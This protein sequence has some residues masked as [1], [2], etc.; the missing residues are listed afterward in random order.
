[1]L[2]TRGGTA[3]QPN[4][5]DVINQDVCIGCARCFKVCPRAVLQ[6]AGMTEDGEQVDFDD[7]EAFRKIMTVEDAADCIGCGACAKVCSTT[8]M[9]F[10]AA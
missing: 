10:V 7:D 8:A 5:L 2:Q 4:Y 6:P 9:A 3:W 1:M